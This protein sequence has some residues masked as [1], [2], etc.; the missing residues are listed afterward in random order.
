MD[1]SHQIW[2]DTTTRHKNTVVSCSGHR[3]DIW[4]PYILS[5]H[6]GW[7]L[8]LC[9][10]IS[11]MSP[12][13]IHPQVSCI[14]DTTS[15][16]LFYWVLT[17]DD[18]SDY[19]TLYPQGPEGPDGMGYPIFLPLTQRTR[20]QAW[21]SVIKISIFH[22]IPSHHIIHTCTGTYSEQIQSRVTFH[23]AQQATALIV[24]FR[25]QT[26]L[27]HHP[28]WSGTVPYGPY[29]RPTKCQGSNSKKE[30]T[31]KPILLSLQTLHLP[32]RRPNHCFKIE[33][34]HDRIHLHAR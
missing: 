25:Y 29:Q 20:W 1:Q 8:T 6:F 7:N 18:N 30:G 28:Q 2:S 11:I 14:D 3:C 13:V 5:C 23:D 15:Y 24:S 10:M 34:R 4:P 27:A 12:L 31:P 33:I 9:K 16:S 21:Y 17:W 19:F 22:T 32:F 26:W